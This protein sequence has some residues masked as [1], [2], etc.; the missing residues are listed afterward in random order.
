M[1]KLIQKLVRT[2]KGVGQS[3]GFKTTSNMTE[4]SLTLVA[5]LDQYHI[6]KGIGEVFDA[7]AD[8]VM[9]TIN[10][11]KAESMNQI[12]T[13][14]GDLLWGMWLS[15]GGDESLKDIVDVGADFL[16]FDGNNVAASVF[17]HDEMG[18]ILLIEPSYDNMYL[19][20]VGHMP[21]DAVVVQ[22]A[23]GNDYVSVEDVVRCRLVASLTG[24]PLLVDVGSGVEGEGLIALWEVGTDGIVVRGD[25]GE[26]VESL[27]NITDNAKQ[28][29]IRRN[30]I[31]KSATLSMPS[32]EMEKDED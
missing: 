4:S 28:L 14:M 12:R 32:V 10:E 5:A 24:K 15:E 20:I 16:A 21:V 25:V 31:S 13:A 6:R 23:R 9:A 17:Q 19:G 2:S 18:K 26:V 3:L 30:S 27:R 22:V 29:P 7:G 11:D 8:A 1:S